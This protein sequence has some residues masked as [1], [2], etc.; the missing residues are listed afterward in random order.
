MLIFAVIAVFSV[1]A[2]LVLSGSPPQDCTWRYTSHD[3]GAVTGTC[4][5]N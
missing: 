3:K 2:L 4:V 5:P 1:I